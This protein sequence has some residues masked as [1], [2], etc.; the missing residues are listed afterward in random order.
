MATTILDQLFARTQP[1]ENGCFIWTGWVSGKHDPYP[2]IQQNYKRIL[3]HRLVWTIV[4]GPI[5]EN[6]CILHRC[7]TP[8][9]IN[10]DHLFI[11][12]RGDNNKDRH[13]KGRGSNP[14]CDAH[15]RAG[16]TNEQVRIIKI[17]LANGES[18]LLLAKEFS[19]TGHVVH[20]IKTGKNWKGIAI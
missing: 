16:L 12:T 11:G 18:Y 13:A 20:K 2:V 10:P 15:P 9:C 14:S 3:V 8:R 7:D 19:V 5:A 4:K 1:N 17:R 6:L